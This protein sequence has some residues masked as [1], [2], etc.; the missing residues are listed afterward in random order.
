LGVYNEKSKMAAGERSML[1]QA[2]MQLV[3][4]GSAG[5]KRLKQD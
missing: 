2:G 4:G 3:A 5:K 1:K